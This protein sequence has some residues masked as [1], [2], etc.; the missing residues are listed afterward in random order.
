ML[1]EQISDRFF[2]VGIVV[3]VVPG[4]PGIQ[5]FGV[6]GRLVRRG[7]GEAAPLGERVGVLLPHGVRIESAECLGDLAPLGAGQGL[8]FGPLT[9]SGIARVRTTQAGAA[10]GL[11]NSVHQLGGA[12]GMSLVLA[13]STSYAEAM[14]DGAF[15]L[16]L[17]VLVASALVVPATV[18]RRTT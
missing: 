6:A 4:V 5:V 10:S 11:V 2:R 13:V 14:R 18:R 9:A 1:V 7:L 17:A 3:L 8:A 15:L 16:G 12:L